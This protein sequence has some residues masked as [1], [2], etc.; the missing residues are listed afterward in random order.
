M[1]PSLGKFTIP[2]DELEALRDRLTPPTSNCFAVHVV[3]MQYACIYNPFAR[4]RSKKYG[5]LSF[6]A[7]FRV[8]DSPSDVFSGSKCGV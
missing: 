8:S 2:T 6:V 1:C 3:S 4:L 7:G 5:V